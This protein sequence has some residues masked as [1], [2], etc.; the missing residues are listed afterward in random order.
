MGSLP[1]GVSQEQFYG[2]ADSGNRTD[3]QGKYQYTNLRDVIE[4]FQ[5][6]YT[7][8]DQLVPATVNRD[9]IIFHAK[10]GLQELNFDTLNE[11]KAIE[12]DI[13]PETL[14][15]ILPEDFINVVRVSWVDAAG[16]FHPMV[17][18]EDTRIA[19]AYLQ[20]NTYAYLYD[21]E[22]NVLLA[23]QNSYDQSNIDPQ[24]RPMNFINDTNFSLGYDLYFESQL[25][26]RFGM[27]TSKAN[28]NGWYTIDKPNGVMYFSSNIAN[29]QQNPSA[30]EQKSSSLVIEY[31][32]DGIEGRTLSDIR[33][34]K[35]AEEALYQYIQWQLVSSRFDVQEYIVRRARKQYENARRTAKMRLAGL[36]YAD[37]LQAMRGKDKRIK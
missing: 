31:I 1:N 34:H 12:V 6:M 5:F 23:D 26:G 21:D 32:S 4:N 13:D 30:G 10:R 14:R 37:L 19:S 22:G 9:K 36:T 27:E 17:T 11:I 16:Y 3:L 20:D 28:F 25:K 35:F 29:L 8:A 18:N 33:V 7:G 2:D 15:L 24:Y